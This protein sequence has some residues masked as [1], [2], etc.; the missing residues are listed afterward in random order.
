[1]KQPRITTIIAVAA[2]GVLVIFAISVGCD[3]YRGYFKK[4]A[5]AEAAKMKRTMILDEAYTKIKKV[6]ELTA[7]QSR[8]KAKVLAIL[9]IAEQLARIAEALEEKR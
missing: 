8:E 2:V 7:E 4:A 1:M 9:A 5:I 3:V 6:F